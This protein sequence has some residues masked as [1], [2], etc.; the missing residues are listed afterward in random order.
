MYRLFAYLISLTAGGYAMAS[1]KE[2]TWLDTTF[3]ERA[4]YEVAL[5][6]EFE[7]G[8]KPLIKWISPVKVWYQHDVP[9]QKLHESLAADQFAQIEE[10]TSLSITRARNKNDANFFV[11]FTRQNMWKN[12]VKEILGNESAEH[13]DGATCIFGIGV[14]QRTR[15]I[16][17]AAVFIPV[18]QAREQGK[19][20]S[21]VVEEITQAFGLKNDSD[22]AYPSVF[23]DHTP[24]AFLSPLDIVMMRLLYQPSLKPG[25]NKQ[26]LKPL[27]K[28][29]LK[30]MKSSGY[31][32]RA[33]SISRQ[34]PLY[35]K[36]GP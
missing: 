15:E 5:K 4:F 9:N 18:D 3:I 35:V 28:F 8:T 29:M 6:S 31:L 23:N 14:N 24:Q 25:M 27:V 16:A 34:A 1:S 21:C 11:Y 10:L 12:R 30:K 20:L 33:L 22:L 19:L 7:K 17:H 36:Y 2:Q 26:Q 13:T 32:D